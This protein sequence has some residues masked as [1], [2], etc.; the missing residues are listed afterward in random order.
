MKQ[1]IHKNGGRIMEKEFNEL[2]KNT[3]LI[4]H[5]NQGMI[6]QKMKNAILLMIALIYMNILD[7]QIHSELHM[8]ESM[9][10]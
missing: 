4:I 5:I 6:Y 2:Y 8:Q 10:V 9:K 1:E 3:D 7:L